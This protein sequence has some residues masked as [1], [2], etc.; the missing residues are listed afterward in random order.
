MAAIIAFNGH[1]RRSL[2]SAGELFKGLR[3]ENLSLT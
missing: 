2:D 3:P 1:T